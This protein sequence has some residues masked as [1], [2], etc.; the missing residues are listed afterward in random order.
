MTERR[1]LSV[2]LPKLLL[3]V[4]VF[5]EAGCSTAGLGMA[6]ANFYLGC[7]DRAVVN[8]ESISENDTDAVL[9]FM[10]RGMIQHVKGD[11]AAS[12]HDWEKAVEIVEYL[13]YYSLSRRSASIIINDQVISFRGAPYEIMLLHAFS[14]KNFWAL[15]QWNDAA[16]EARNII[17]LFENEN[18][19]DFPLDPY[20]RY[21]AAF[22]MEMAHDIDGA[23]YEYRSVSNMLDD[24]NIDTQTGSITA[25]QD[26]PSTGNTTDIRLEQL[27]PSELVCFISIGQSP[28]ENACACHAN[29]RWGS[30]PYAEIYCDG[31]YAGRSYTFANTHELMKA[32]N[33]KRAALLAAKDTIRI[34]IKDAV[35]NA[36]SEKNAI[37]GEILRLILFSC[38]AP[39]SRRWETLPLYLQIAR[40]PCPDN[41]QSYEVIFK[42][43]DGQILARRKITR[44]LARRDNVIVSFCREL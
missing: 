26:H 17:S 25:D 13:D 20:S 36:V 32:T 1:A 15:E 31:K 38:E 16:V 42:R 18:L 14:A 4:L 9:L 22:C 8:L 5:I 43:K 6:R 44:P 29:Y 2:Y 34:L 19:A 3:L 7:F 11:Y 12:A 24:I 40:V 27:W 37:T 10:E 30:A 23:L 28:A 41:L 35:A 33:E 21:V 39:D